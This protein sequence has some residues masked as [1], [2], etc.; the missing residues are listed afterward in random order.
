M[1]LLLTVNPPPPPHTDM[2]FALKSKTTPHILKLPYKEK[3]FM[4]AVGSEDTERFP[5]IVFDLLRVPYLSSKNL[6]IFK[7]THGKRHIV[8]I[9]RLKFQRK[10]EKPALMNFDFLLLAINLNHVPLRIVN[11][12]VTT[13]TNVNIFFMKNVVNVFY[14]SIVL[15]ILEPFIMQIILDSLFKNHVRNTICFLKKFF[16]GVNRQTNIV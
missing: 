3:H 1:S 7:M 13:K 2:Q 5:V 4:H 15:E 6:Y 11:W 9:A 12:P 14:F 10:Q 16:L 8:L